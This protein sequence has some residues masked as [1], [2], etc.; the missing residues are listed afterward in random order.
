ME[1]FDKVVLLWILPSLLVLLLTFRARQ[2]SPDEDFSIRVLISILWP[3]GLVAS[4]TL[5]FEDYGFWK[6][7]FKEVW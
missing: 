5:I 7:L 2:D 1:V 4:I 6:F 3:L